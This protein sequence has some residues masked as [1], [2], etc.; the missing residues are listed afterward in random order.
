M[1]FLTVVIPLIY[2]WSTTPMCEGTIH[3][4]YHIDMGIFCCA[5][6][7]RGCIN[8]S[9]WIHGI[10]SSPLDKMAA[11]S[12]TTLANTF[13]WIKSFIFWLK[14]HWCLF[15]RVL[16]TIHQR[17]FRQW[18][19]AEHAT[20]YYLKK[21]RPSLLTHICGSWGRWLKLPYSSRVLWWHC[22]N[23]NFQ[24]EVTLTDIDKSDHS[25]HKYNK[26]SY[27]CC[28]LMA[29]SISRCRHTNSMWP[30]GVTMT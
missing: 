29:V 19:G 12:Q 25:L 7:C 16:L 14:F 26:M 2:C 30:Y 18:L 23:C 28:R 13:L 10:N 9:L 21:M 22:G 6:F 3:A 8:S 20:S 1:E 4:V 27:S 24:Y 5:S 15:L 11:I 17:W